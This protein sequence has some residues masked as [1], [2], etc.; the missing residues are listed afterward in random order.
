L[1]ALP[2][3]HAMLAVVTPPSLTTQQWEHLWQL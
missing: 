1:L 3:S 2:L